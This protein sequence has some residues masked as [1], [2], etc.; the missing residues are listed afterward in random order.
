MEVLEIIIVILLILGVLVSIIISRPMS[1]HLVAETEIKR[2]GLFQ[3][4]FFIKDYYK[5]MN[6]ATEK[7]KKKKFKI[8][9]IIFMITNLGFILSAILLIIIPGTS[10]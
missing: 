8:Y 5:M 9:Y 2:I 1:K 3:M 10:I 6:D 4:P 7:S